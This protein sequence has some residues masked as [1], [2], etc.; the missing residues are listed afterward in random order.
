MDAD[1]LR[2]QIGAITFEHPYVLG[3]R[4]PC[5]L[6]FIH[7]QVEKI[8]NR[9]LIVTDADEMRLAFTGKDNFRFDIAKE[10]PYKGN[11]EAISKPYHWSSVDDFIKAKYGRMVVTCTGYEADDYLAFNRTYDDGKKYFICTRD[12]DLLTVPG[13]HYRWACG[14]KQP[15]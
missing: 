2:Y 4:I 11:R 9:C 10:Q 7:E 5:P 8:V 13:W 12:K 6:P 15:F 3:A 14:E 1:I